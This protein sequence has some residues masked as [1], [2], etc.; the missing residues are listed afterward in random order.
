[1]ENLISDDDN[2]KCTELY[3]FEYYNGK[4]KKKYSGLDY[5]IILN[6]ECD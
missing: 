6:N 2:Y 1:M 3:N 4:C 5:L